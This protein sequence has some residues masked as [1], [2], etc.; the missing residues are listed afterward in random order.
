MHCWF[1]GGSVLQ[2]AM[3]LSLAG[4]VGRLAPSGALR[5]ITFIIA[6][7]ALYACSQGVAPVAVAAAAIASWIA[8]AAGGALLA[9]GVGALGR[10]GGGASFFCS[11][12]AVSA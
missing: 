8:R 4:M 3:K 6:V 9:T 2:P 11:Q 7:N 5:S 12:P 10:A 1:S